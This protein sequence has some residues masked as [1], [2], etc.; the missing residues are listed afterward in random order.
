M[1]IL[2]ILPYLKILLFLYQLIFHE[3]YLSDIQYKPVLYYN[4][5]R[6]SLQYSMKKLRAGKICKQHSKG[7][8]K[9]KQRFKFFNYRKIKQYSDYNIHN[10]IFINRRISIRHVCYASCF[11][12]VFYSFQHMFQSIL[13]GFC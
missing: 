1:I 4:I 8:R 13:S 7:Y 2:P 6:H 10:Q 12:K 9:Q 3:F 5:H 11:K